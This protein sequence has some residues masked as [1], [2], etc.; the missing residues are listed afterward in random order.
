[1]AAVN[2]RTVL[3][4]ALGLATAAALPRAYA[5]LTP[6]SVADGFTLLSGGG[7]NILVVATTEGAIL[8]DSGAADAAQG[9]VPAIGEMQGDTKVHTLFNSHWHLDQ[10]GGNETLGRAGAN[11]VAH[12]KTRLRL[13]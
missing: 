4:G 2:R 5:K 10:I 3:S 7:G 6:A 9:L 13:A 8:V 11:I 12:E 1:M